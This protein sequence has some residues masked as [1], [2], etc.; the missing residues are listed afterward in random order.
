MY[1][2]T[3][4]HLPEKITLKQLCTENADGVE[5]CARGKRESMPG[6]VCLGRGFNKQGHS[7]E[8]SAL[9]WRNGDCDMADIVQG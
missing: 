9:Q 5:H 3:H 8:V 4:N 6:F 7:I 1:I 2:P